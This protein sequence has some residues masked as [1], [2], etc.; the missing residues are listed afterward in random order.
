MRSWHWRTQPERLAIRLVDRQL[1]APLWLSP[2]SSLSGVSD[3]P[4][5]MAVSAGPRRNFGRRWCRAGER[6][7]T[8]AGR[9]VR[10]A[11]SQCGGSGGVGLWVA[12]WW[13]MLP[14]WLAA[15]RSAESRD[16]A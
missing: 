16:L 8:L 14:R 9:T 11:R 10:V 13:M 1:Q 5:L 4:T 3:P 6:L 2:V 7:A 12:W 15:L